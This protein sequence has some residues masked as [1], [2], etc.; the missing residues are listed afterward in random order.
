MKS[1]RLILMMLSLVSLVLY[2]CTSTAS[3]SNE[4]HTTPDSNFIVTLDSSNGSIHKNHEENVNLTP[5]A[6]LKFSHIINADTVNSKNIILTDVSNNQIKLQYD[7]ND[8][9][10]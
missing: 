1:S 2:G 8:L 3:S 4:T 10:T 9:T 5:N 7:I 6:V